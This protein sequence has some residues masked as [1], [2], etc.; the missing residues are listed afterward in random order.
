MIIDKILYKFYFMQN[1]I[2]YSFINISKV[3]IL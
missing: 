3:M 1:L 2:K